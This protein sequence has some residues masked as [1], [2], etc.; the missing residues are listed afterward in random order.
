MDNL[1]DA[2]DQLLNTTRGWVRSDTFK[3]KINYLEHSTQEAG[4]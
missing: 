2:V 4:H 1:A 3:F